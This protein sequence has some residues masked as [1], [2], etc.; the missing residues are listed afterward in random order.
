[1]SG[2]NSWLPFVCYI[3]R[4]GLGTECSLKNTSCVMSPSFHC[5]YSLVHKRR[6]KTSFLSALHPMSVMESVK[7][8]SVVV[9]QLLQVCSSDEWLPVNGALLGNVQIDLSK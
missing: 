4:S 8:F 1:M 2:A 9:V 3:V 5:Y 6:H 7:C